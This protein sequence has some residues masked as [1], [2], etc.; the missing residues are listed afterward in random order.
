MR[1]IAILN[2]FAGKARVDGGKVGSL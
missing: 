2:E 1:L